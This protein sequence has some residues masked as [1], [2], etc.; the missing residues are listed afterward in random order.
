MSSAKN[1]RCDLT[2]GR[3]ERR[4]ARRSSQTAG[5]V[6]YFVA[7]MGTGGTLMGVAGYLRSIR[8]AVACAIEA[9]SVDD[10][11]IRKFP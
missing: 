2:S 11:E 10:D 4:R 9:N 7:G 8:A 5:D 1:G 6:D 3:I